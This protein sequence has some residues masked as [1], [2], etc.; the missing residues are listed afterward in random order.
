MAAGSIAGG[1]GRRP[2]PVP[3]SQKPAGASGRWLHGHM[4]ELTHHQSL[5][6][7]GRPPAF[8]RW[9]QKEVAILGE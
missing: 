8:L 6:A 5:P 1:C 4:A 2:A 9:P 7:V 3:R